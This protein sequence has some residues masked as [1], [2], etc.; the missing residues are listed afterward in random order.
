MFRIV[1]AREHKLTT[2]KNGLGVTSEIAVH[3][4]GSDLDSFDWRVSMAQ[5]GA[6]GPFSIF[7]DVDR[8][9]AVLEGRLRL[10]IAG[11]PPLELSP[12]SPTAEFPGDVPVT[13][14]VVDGP[15]TD[16]NVM[17]RRG[18][19]TAHLQ[20]LHID[21]PL[22]RAV[23]ATTLLL[24]RT[25]GLR[26]VCADRTDV[27]EV[28]DAVISRGKTDRHMRLEPQGPSVAFLIELT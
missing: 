16:L 9:L 13:A 2:W 27:L 15:V 3:P 26:L 20:R 11:R 25:G 18:R 4:E 19:A 12:G 17:T 10:E 5:V 1:R 24:S 14:S 21:T 28:N 22:E 23:T 7:A 6:D 8:H